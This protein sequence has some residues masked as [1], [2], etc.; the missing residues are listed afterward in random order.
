MMK[1]MDPDFRQTP[2][3]RM[4]LQGIANRI[5]SALFSRK[6]EPWQ[7]A[8]D[9][10]DMITLDCG[11][12]IRI[13]RLVQF[14]TYGGLQVGYPNKSLNDRL[15]KNLVEKNSSDPESGIKAILIDPPRKI[16]RSRNFGEMREGPWESLPAITC[17]A[18]LMS[19]DPLDD[20]DPF[21]NVSLLTVVWFQDQYAMPIDER[22]LN[23]I[24]KIVWRSRA[25][26]SFSI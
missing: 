9:K 7:D 1:S 12:K 18:N 6:A 5:F 8:A 23:Q 15:L 26:D 11:R 14:W 16:E 21:M 24:R 17:I 2:L 19:N 4:R 25:F 13:H 10:D 3:H 20:E 22:A